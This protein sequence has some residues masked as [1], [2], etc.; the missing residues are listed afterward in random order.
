MGEKEK[1]RKEGLEPCGS[2][3]FVLKTRKMVMTYIH[4]RE[5]AG[6]SSEGKS[7]KTDGLEEEGKLFFSISL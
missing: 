1:K 4:T 7:R 5:Y 2:V 3:L 6:E